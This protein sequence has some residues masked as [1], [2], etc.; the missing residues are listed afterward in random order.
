MGLLFLTVISSF[1]SWTNLICKSTEVHRGMLCFVW[2][3][4]QMTK[5]GRRTRY[6]FREPECHYL[7]CILMFL[8]G[9]LVVHLPVTYLPSSLL[10][11]SL[12]PPREEGSFASVEPRAKFCPL[13]LACIIKVVSMGLLYG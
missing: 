6:K 13:L 3:S 4:F 1:T 9:S 7:T 12:F 2:Q 8:P 5:V 11:C 10:I